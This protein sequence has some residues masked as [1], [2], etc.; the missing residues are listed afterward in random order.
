MNIDDREHRLEKI[1]N[2]INNR[3][4]IILKEQTEGNFENP[5]VI[6]QYENE[7]AYKGSK[8]FLMNPEKCDPSSLSFKVGIDEEER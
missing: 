3:S 5:S 8:C 4:E 7:P 2:K 1:R 6:S